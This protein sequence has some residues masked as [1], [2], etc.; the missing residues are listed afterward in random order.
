MSKVCKS[1][2]AETNFFGSHDYS[3][4]KLV[5]EIASVFLCAECEIMERT[6]DNSSFLKL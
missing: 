6:F 3:K 5:A 2:V 4:E 1:Y